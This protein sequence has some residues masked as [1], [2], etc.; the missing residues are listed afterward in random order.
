MAAKTKPKSKKKWMQSASKSIKKRG[1]AGSF[2]RWCKS[3]GYSGATAACIAEGKRS[4]SAT[5]RRRATLAG[6]YAK[7]SRGRKKSK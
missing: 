5:I 6:N 7:A 3:R 2:V 4:K 1:T